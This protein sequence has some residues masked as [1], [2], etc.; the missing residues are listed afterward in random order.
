MQTPDHPHKNDFTSLLFCD[1]VRF[2]CWN[3]C[4]IRSDHVMVH[5]MA[6]GRNFPHQF[7]I[8]QSWR[9][10]S[11]Y[12]LLYS[13]GSEFS[14]SIPYLTIRRT[15]IPGCLECSRTCEWK[16]WPQAS[17]HMTAH[18]LVHLFMTWPSSSWPLHPWTSSAPSTS[19]IIFIIPSLHI[20]N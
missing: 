9:L 5:C 19:H 11:R 2:S 10:Q 17:S 12:S 4:Q 16:Q 14:A 15:A 8:W 7:H 18:V 20:R 6:A 13:S 3:G 1:I